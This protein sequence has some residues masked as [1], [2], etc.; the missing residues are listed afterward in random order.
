MPMAL[1]KKLYHESLG[2]VKGGFEM[3]GLWEWYYKIPFSM[4]R[5]V[6][7]HDVLQRNKVICKNYGDL[8][9][10]DVSIDNAIVKSH[11]YNPDTGVCHVFVDLS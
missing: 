8:R 4:S 7:V 3:I 9:S 5:K 10:D 1:V 2:T 11:R 6:R